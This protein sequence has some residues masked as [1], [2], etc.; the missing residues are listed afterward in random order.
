M[1]IVCTYHGVERTWEVAE[2]EFVIGRAHENSPLLLDLSPDKTV[3]RVHARIW[4]ET[5]NHWIEDLQSARGTLLNNDEIKGA[6]RRKLV[7]GDSIVVGETSLCFNSLECRDASSETNYLQFGAD[8]PFDG[9]HTESQIDIA[10]DLDATNFDLGPAKDSSSIEAHRLKLICELPLRFAAKSQLEDLLP[11]IVDSLVELIPSADSWA[12]ALLDP[13]SNALLLKAYRSRSGPHISESLARRAMRERKAFVW[14]RASTRE[15]TRTI[16]QSAMFT[17]V[18]APLLWQ[19]EEFG[20]ICAE[21]I[22]PGDIFGEEDLRLIVFMAQYAAMAV[23]GHRLQER[24]R[25]ESVLK[26]KLLRQFSPKIADRLLTYRGRLRLGG[27]RSEVTILNS[28]IRGFTNLTRDMDPDDIVEMLNDYYH[29]E[30]PILFAYGGT[31]DKFMGD[32]ILAVFGSPE[33]DAKQCEH[34]V[35]AAV[36]MQAAVAKVNERRR[37]RGLPCAEPGIG[38]HC[39]EVMHG[40]VGTSDRMEFTVIGEAVNKTSRYCSAAGK[41]EILISPE[42]HER[43][44]KMVQIDPSTI[45]TKHEGTFT[46]Y[47]VIGIKPDPTQEEKKAGSEEQRIQPI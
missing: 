8:L 38:I 10:R 24:L 28:D 36:E 6:G 11:A 27:E 19:D 47:R 43:V 13:Q 16:L 30:V 39:G 4:K 17:G 20:V 21:S 29:V 34:A 45:Q 25:S 31:I 32:A 33:H 40:F 7:P 9:P 14:N 5:G 26:A 2:D 1:R 18:Y 46:A 42:V 3:S 12:I 15:M 22:S 37:S 35:L 23:G 44:W 41:G